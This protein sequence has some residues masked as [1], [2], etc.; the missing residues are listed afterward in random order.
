MVENYRITIQLPKALVTQACEITQLD[1]TKTIKA[2]LQ[3]MVNKNTYKK[4]DSLRG[5]MSK[6]VK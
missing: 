4:L 1:I 2:A 6:E 3:E 5:F